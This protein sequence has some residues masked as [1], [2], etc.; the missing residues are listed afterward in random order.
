MAKIYLISPQDF[1]PLLHQEKLEKAFATDKVSAFQLRLK[2][3]E[4][5]KIEEIAIQTLEIC[6]KYNILFIINDDIDLAVKIKAGGVHL[7][8]DDYESLAE[9]KKN[10][11]ENF[12]I[13]TSCYDS[14]DLALDS[15][16][17]D[18]DYI[19]FGA[20]YASKT[21]KSR[22]QPDI[23]ILKWANELFELP[24]VAIGGIDDKN[25]KILVQSGADF[26]AIISYFWDH[27]DPVLAIENLYRQ[28]N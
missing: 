18:V 25:S 12:V 27:E 20:F 23:S 4:H 17:A 9:I 11:P 1:D 16:L 6:K 13:G 22:G 28:I 26:V 21:K 24:I 5:S 8:V 10:L 14:R 3:L 7:G 19:S 2:D 15:V